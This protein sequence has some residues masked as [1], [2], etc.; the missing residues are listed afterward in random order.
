MVIKIPYKNTFIICLVGSLNLS[1]ETKI[2][3]IN[4]E[5]K[6]VAR[7]KF[8]NFFKLQLSSDQNLK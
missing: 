8:T 3:I 5:G 6:I 2:K 4:K 1:E 7:S